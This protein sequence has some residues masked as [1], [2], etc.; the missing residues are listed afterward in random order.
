MDNYY[1]LDVEKLDQYIKIGDFL[2]ERVVTNIDEDN[3][4]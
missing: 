3:Y 4:Y 2:P 1:D